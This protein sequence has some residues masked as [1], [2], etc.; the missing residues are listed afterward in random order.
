MECEEG[1]DCWFLEAEGEDGV[2]VARVLAK[3]EVPV[4]RFDTD[5][6]HLE[7][8]SAGDQS[9]PQNVVSRIAEYVAISHVWSE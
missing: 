7:V 8:L 3:G 1:K 2:S 9:L 6:G 4:V 5:N